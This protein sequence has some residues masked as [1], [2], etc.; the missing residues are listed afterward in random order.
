MRWLQRIVND[1]KN[2]ELVLDAVAHFQR[3]Y[4]DGK[5]ILQVKGQRIEVKLTRIASEIEYYYA[6]YQEIEMILAHMDKQV[7]REIVDQTQNYM[8]HYNRKISE[9]TAR[10]YAEVH[11]ETLVLAA[12]RMQVAMVRNDFMALFKGLETLS[13]KLKDIVE[14]RKAML[15]DAMFV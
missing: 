8:D 7:E 6:T 13:F 9:Q 15:D 3:E 4:E 10:K 11:D 14:L 12:V 5:S 2:L 1:A